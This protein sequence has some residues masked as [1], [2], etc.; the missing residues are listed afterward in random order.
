MRMRAPNMVPRHHNLVWLDLLKAVAMMWIFLNHFVERIFGFPE[1]ANPTNAWLPLEERISQLLPLSG[2]GIL[3]IP[4]N[5]LRYVG[6]FG[7]QGVQLFLIASGFGITFGLLRQGAPSLDVTRFYWR[8]FERILPMWWVAHIVLVP[9]LLFAGSIRPTD[10]NILFSFFGVRILSEQ[11]YFLE[12]SWWYIGLLLQLYLVYPLLWHVLH[13]LGP[14]KFMVI[15]TM[16]AFVVR[17]VGLAY[18]DDYLDAW[19]RGA[20]FITRLPEFVFGM[21]LAWGF[22]TV[23]VKASGILKKPG[24]IILALVIYIL[25]MLLSLTLWG[26]TV[27][28]FMLGIGAFGLL[29]LPLTAWSTSPSKTLNLVVWIGTHSYSIFLVHG[30]CIRLFVPPGGSILSSTVWFGCAA[31]ILT[32]AVG[33]YGLEKVTD[34]LIKTVKLVR[35]SGG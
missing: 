11:L 17:G 21:V 30:L 2:N 13:T 20:I 31:A 27:A 23:P 32:T 5:L 6:W 29:F 22:H 8:R 19:S 24:T 4:I 3:D 35:R 7:D 26:M 16:L 15:M 12:G 10:I 25:G 18:F 33:S 34:Y 1:I 14:G 28:V 9:I